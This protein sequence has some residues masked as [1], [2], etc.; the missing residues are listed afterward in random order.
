MTIE[1]AT[2]PNDLS[3][4]LVERINARDLDGLVALY[5]DDAVLDTGDGLAVG[6]DAIR[7]FWTRLLA[8]APTVMLGQQTEPLVNGDLALTSTC[9]PGAFV[10]AEVARR[11]PDGSWRWIIDQ[12]ALPTTDSGA[13]VM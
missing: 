4:L 12:P 11:Q 1:Q 10:T 6:A 3:R 9:V 8:T 2:D 13:A 5:E 7:E